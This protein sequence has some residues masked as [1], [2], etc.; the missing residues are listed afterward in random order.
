MITLNMKKRNSSWGMGTYL[1]D[2]YGVKTRFTLCVSEFNEFFGV[3]SDATGV[4][5]EF[6]KTQV[7][8]SYLMSCTRERTMWGGI[9]LNTRLDGFQTYLMGPAK[10]T[11]KRLLAD[12]Y[13][14]VRVTHS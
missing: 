3:P 6:T 14:Y 8:D 13:K 11:M 1:I 4:R 12:G 2:P 9:E 10:Q 7:D 5:F